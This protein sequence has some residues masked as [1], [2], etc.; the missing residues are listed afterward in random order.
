MTLE[1]LR[2]EN[3]A[4]KD[5]GGVSG[6]NRAHG[7]RPAFLDPATGRVYPSR[8]ADGTPAP[9]HLLEGLSNEVKRMA[10]SGFLRGEAFYTREQ[11]AQA[12]RGTLLELPE[13]TMQIGSVVSL[14]APSP[15][16]ARLPS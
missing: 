14:E 8:F 5:T 9:I 12:F 4:F 6:N 1:K 10:I 16:D 11:A 2:R 3:E 15:S 7:F 13:T